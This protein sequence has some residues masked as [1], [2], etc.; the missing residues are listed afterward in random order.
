MRTLPSVCNVECRASTAAGPPQPRAGCVV[1]CACHPQLS[2]RTDPAPLTAGHTLHAASACSAG[3]LLISLPLSAC[4]TAADLSPR[5]DAL[6]PKDDTFGRLLLALLQ[7][8]DPAAPQ[9]VTDDPRGR[10]F[11]QLCPPDAFEVRRAT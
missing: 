5:W 2:L 6:L 9:C 7:L 10:Y 4:I 8:T 11:A 1:G 3:D